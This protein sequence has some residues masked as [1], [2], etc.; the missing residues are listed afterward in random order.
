MNALERRATF[1]LAAMYALRMFGLFMLLPV[2]PLLATELAGS[3]PQ[4]IGLALGVYGLTQALLQIPFGLLSDHIDRRQVI[5]AGIFLFVAGS[6]VAATSD[7][8]LGVILG[9]ALQGSGAVAAAI[10]ALLADLTSEEQRTKA[11]AAVGI[12]IGVS[13][14][15]A[16]VLGPI[17]G[18]ALGLQG[19]FWFVAF[20]GMA[21]LPV[22]WHFV[23]SPRVSRPHR[24]AIAVP[25]Q[26]F[27]ALVDPN[28]WRLHLSIFLLHALM[29]SN[30]LVLPGLLRDL[31]GLPMGRHWLV[32]LPVMIGAVALMVPMV[33]IAERR[34][35]LKSVFC[36][37]VG[38][39]VGTEFWFAA[40]GNSAVG[41]V[42]GLLAFFVSFNCLE[43]LLPSLVS[44]GARL[45]GKGTALGV[46]TTAQF[47]GAFVG[48]VGGGWLVGV[49][50]VWV[51]IIAGCIS[52]VWL[53]VVLGMPTPRM[54]LTRLV[55]LGNIRQEQ[56]A[57]FAR[58][59][60]AL[61]GVAEVVVL[62][63]EGVAYLRVDKDSFDASALSEITQ[64]AT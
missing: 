46:Y 48:G 37:S 9:R 44:R 26:I 36:A 55:N 61:P 60:A 32:Y 28:L 1:S 11:M 45:D 24:D 50:P 40:I 62:A 34:G 23:P 42:V 57:A 25:S 2:L 7:S 21:T 56:V 39:L 20:L 49:G 51:F 41:L 12:S 43:S 14:M 53:G 29:V 54:L 58:R 18:A 31:S 47:L 16:M 4:L 15:V 8:I 30:F 33:L 13:Y 19:L 52:L 5:T 63:D 22:L 17:L 10:M 3:T 27:T 38:L 35:H 64:T 6:V 59:I